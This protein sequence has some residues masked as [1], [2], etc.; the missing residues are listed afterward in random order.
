LAGLQVI[1]GVIDNYYT[2]QITILAS[3]PSGPISI[4]KGQRVA[5]LILLPLKST[6]KSNIQR[7]R[8]DSAFG[9]SDAYWVQQITAERPLLTLKL[10]GKSFEGLIDT[11]A[12]ATVIL[13]R[14]W[15]PRLALRSLYNTS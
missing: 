3:A 1:P 10:D 4:S 13:A 2:G 14:Y 5:Q 7:P 6:N 12:D 9:S 8:L 15:P 11:A